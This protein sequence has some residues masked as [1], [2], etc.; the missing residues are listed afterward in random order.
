MNIEVRKILELI[1]ND[2]YECYIVGGY[3]RDYILG[4]N[5]KD[6]DICTN[7]PLDRLKYIL[8]NYKYNIQFNTININ[9]KDINIDITP[10]RRE[11]VYYKRKPIKYEFTNKLQDDMQRRDFT[12]NS[13]CMDC[14][15]NIVDLL[16]GILDIYN[17]QIKC[18][19][20]I[21]RKLIEDPLRIL[22]AIRFKVYLNFNIEK[23]LEIGI[24]KYG[25]LLKDLSYK[26]KKRELDKIIKYK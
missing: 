1:N 18:I 3:I 24:K 9:I 11:F 15:G 20:N 8:R 6:Y 10:Y 2:N 21:D 17:K 23:N 5:S 4:I 16:N 7:A 12:I 25:Y 26:I 22:R 13:I 14:N 19:E